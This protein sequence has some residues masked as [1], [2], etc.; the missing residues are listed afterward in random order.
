MLTPSIGAWATPLMAAGIGI[1]STSSTV[2][3]TSMACVNCVRTSPRARMP[4]GQCTTNG[5]A[6]PPRV[7]SR[8]QR[9]N[10]VLPANAQP[11]ANAGNVSGPP[12]ASFDASTCSKVTG[13]PLKNSTSLGSPSSPPSMLAPLSLVTMNIV[14]SSWPSSSSRA[15]SRPTW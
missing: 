9:M 5:S 15:M 2:G 7:V 10:G 13:T 8:F 1:S 11:A 4:A 3:T 6:V 12:Q 14:S